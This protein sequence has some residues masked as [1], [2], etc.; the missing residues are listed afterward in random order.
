MKYKSETTKQ[1]VREGNEEKRKFR[2]TR[3][4]AL[5]NVPVSKKNSSQI[6]KGRL[7][8]QRDPVK[9][10]RHTGIRERPAAGT[11]QRQ[12]NDP[13]DRDL[14]YEEVEATEAGT[15]NR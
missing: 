14:T 11:R 9:T 3:I 7:Q 15:S 12:P 8:N 4:S 6:R 10:D 5:R 13:T 2:S 1:T